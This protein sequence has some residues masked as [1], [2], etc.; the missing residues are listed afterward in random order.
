MS[1]DP[2]ILLKFILES[3]ENLEKYMLDVDEEAYTSDI[4]KQDAAERRLQVIG[5]AIIQLPQ[6]M[7]DRHP[8]IEWHKI[9]GLRN[10][11]VHDYLDID[12]DLIWHIID[13]SVPEFKIQITGLIQESKK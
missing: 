10:R 9:A 7:K 1:K 12:H 13:E 4:E 3:I 5:Q 6:E 2:V 8:E 11:I